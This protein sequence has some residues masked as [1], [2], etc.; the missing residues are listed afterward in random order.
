MIRKS[1][2]F[3]VWTTIGG[4]CLS[5]QG[6]AQGGV[7]SLCQQALLGTAVGVVVT[8]Q[9]LEQGVNVLMNGAVYTIGGFRRPH[10]HTLSPD[11][12]DRFKCPNNGKVVLTLTRSNGTLCEVT[13]MKQGD[14]YTGVQGECYHGLPSDGQLRSRYLDWPSGKSAGTQRPWDH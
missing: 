3:A 11:E 6:C 9:C 2:Y 8:G 7:Q 5:V 10:Q 1:V 4:A 12:R 14:S 13:L